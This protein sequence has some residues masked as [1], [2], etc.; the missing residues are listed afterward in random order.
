MFYNYNDINFPD[1]RIKYMNLQ[2][3]EYN[4]YKCYNRN[5]K[6]LFTSGS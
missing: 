3:A 2:N 5:D 4:R 6:V 1:I